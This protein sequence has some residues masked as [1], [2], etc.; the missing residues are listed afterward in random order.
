MFVPIIKIVFMKKIV[1]SVFLMTSV[2]VAN[3]QLKDMM[4]KKVGEKVNKN[5]ADKNASKD[6]NTNTNS[7]SNSSPTSTD[8]TVSNSSTPSNTAPSNSSP[9]YNPF[10][11]GG[12]K[13]ILPQYVFQQNVLMETKSWDKKGNLEEKKSSQMRWHFSNQPYNGMEMFDENK[14]SVGFNVFESKKSQMVMLMDNDG[15][16][17]AMVTKIDTAKVNDKVANSNEKSGTKVAK[18]GRTKKILG[19]TCEEWISTDDKGNKT[20]MWISNEVPLTM[21]GSFAMFN[22]GGPKQQ[23]SP[24][25]PSSYPAGFMMEMIS[26]QS[27]GEKFS[28]TAIE[29]N[30]KAEKT[31]STA[32]Y[33]VY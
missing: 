10:M 3:A 8:T 33:V 14:E 24:A 26:Y 25:Y 29:V 6:A 4:L 16:K 18:S 23:S 11:S 12:K 32:G 13:E 15:N 22:R 31:V 20:E 5:K 19:Y 7:N 21:N 27:N 2:I 30:L 28:M 1:V 9:A 17:I